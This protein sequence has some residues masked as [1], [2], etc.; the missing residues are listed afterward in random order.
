MLD[1][2]VTV[3]ADAAEFPHEIDTARAENARTRAERILDDRDNADDEA[4]VAAE[5][6][7]KRALLRLDTAE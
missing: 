7:L 4:L 3:L 2:V 6:A 5:A 1:N